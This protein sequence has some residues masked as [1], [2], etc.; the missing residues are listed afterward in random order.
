M[1]IHGY[2]GSRTGAVMNGV[3]GAVPSRFM[4]KIICRLRLSEVS[5][6]RRR[7]PEPPPSASCSC[8]SCCPTGRPP[9]G[10]AVRRPA[11]GRSCHRGMS[12]PRGFFGGS[13]GSAV[14]S[15]CL[16]GYVS[17]A[18]LGSRSR[19]AFGQLLLL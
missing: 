5:R 10:A 12:P 19:S 18:R 6:Q 3:P 15:H 8:I 7:R 11:S 16:C 17:N 4:R 9:H 2:K 14:R 1:F 13:L